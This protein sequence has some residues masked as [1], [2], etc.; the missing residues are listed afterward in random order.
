MT[1]VMAD[2]IGHLAEI[3]NPA[4]LDGQPGVAQ[5]AGLALRRAFHAQH[6]LRLNARQQSDVID[7][8]HSG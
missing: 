3:G 5:H 7:N 8:L 4:V 2:Q 6:T 1:V